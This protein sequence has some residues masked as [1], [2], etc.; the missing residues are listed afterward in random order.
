MSNVDGW[1]IDN[2]L[3]STADV[4]WAII[5]YYPGLEGDL[6]SSFIIERYGISRTLWI[7]LPVVLR[8]QNLQTY[9]YNFIENINTRF[10]GIHKL[11]ITQRDL[12]GRSNSAL[13][14]GVE[15]LESNFW[16][17][18]YNYLK[19]YGE[20]NMERVK[21]F[22]SANRIKKAAIE[23]A[24]SAFENPSYGGDVSRYLQD[25]PELD[26]AKLKQDYF[27]SIEDMDFTIYNPNTLLYN[28]ANK[29]SVLR[30]TYKFMQNVIHPLESLV[31][32]EIC[33][34]ALKCNKEDILINSWN[35][36]VSMKNIHLRCGVCRGCKQ[37]KRGLSFVD[38]LKDV[39]F[40]E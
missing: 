26:A 3:P 21:L 40:A 35:C 17:K 10:N 8:S 32:N 31:Y 25:H 1:S 4:D 5:F 7:G 33:Q 11:Y 20:V 28:M 37:F 23:L 38:K 34:L 16:L 30:T 12:E 14:P 39:E 24:Y 2:Y 9:S 36:E 6:L 29:T 27:E 15:S 18:T 19:A 13:V 22:T